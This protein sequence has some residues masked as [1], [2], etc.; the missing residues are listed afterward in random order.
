[1]NQTLTEVLELRQY[2]EDRLEAHLA[3]LQHVTQENRKKIF[4][5]KLITYIDELNA[6]CKEINGA[7]CNDGKGP[8]KSMYALINEYQ[9]RFMERY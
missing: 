3:D 8:F 4:N 6:K 5:E 9:N 1:M 7:D 2:A